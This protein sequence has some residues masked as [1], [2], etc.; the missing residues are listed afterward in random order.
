MA[1]QT[2]KINE[3]F[4]TGTTT[5]TILTITPPA[6]YVPGPNGPIVQILPVTSPTGIQFSVGEAIA[7][8]HYAR[9][10]GTV[11]SQS[12]PNLMS[13]HIKQGAAGDTCVITLL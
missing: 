12:L 4:S 5:D 3:L 9:P 1:T 2:V 13:L 7:A 10:A 8:A 6:G 11:F